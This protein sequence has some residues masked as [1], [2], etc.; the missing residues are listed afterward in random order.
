M[1]YLRPRALIER[2][3]GDAAVALMREWGGH[4]VPRLAELHV[5]R[6]RRDAEIRR[7]VRE[8]RDVEGAAEKFRLSVSRIKAIAF[9]S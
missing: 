1:R 8:T 7:Y 5:Q 3:G 9:Y 6:E 4:R 2:I